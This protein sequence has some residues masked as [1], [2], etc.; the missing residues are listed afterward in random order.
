MK[1]EPEQFPNRIQR[2]SSM[3]Q[4]YIDELRDMPKEELIKQGYMSTGKSDPD[5]K[6]RVRSLVEGN[7]K[8][9]F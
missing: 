5:T 7:P 4:E 8:P 6:A 9:P 2:T 1:T 3:T